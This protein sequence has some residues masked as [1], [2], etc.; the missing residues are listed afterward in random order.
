MIVL[1][2]DF[3]YV[4]H[5]LISY[6]LARLY[7]ANRTLPNAAW[8]RLVEILQILA[9]E[10]DDI[11]EVLVMGFRWIFDLEAYREAF[12]GQGKHRG[13]KDQSLGV[14]WHQSCRN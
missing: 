5:E 1:L 14:I 9:L 2:N 4:L 12:G 3:V 6:E 8:K 10:A 7:V 11:S 13:L